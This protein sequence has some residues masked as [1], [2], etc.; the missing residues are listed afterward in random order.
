MLSGA[1]VD[2]YLE[3][4][5]YGGVRVPTFAVLAELH[6]A[7][8]RSV[9]FE[10]LSVRRGEAILLDEQWL[11]EKVV[12]R[13]RGGYCYEL[14]GLLAALLEALGFQ[15]QHLA[16]RVGPTGID[17]DHLA[18]RVELEEP[19]LAD[20]GFGDSFLAPLRLDSRE[21]QDGGEGRSY[22]LEE[23]GDGLVLLRSGPAGWKR[24]FSFGPRGWPLEAFEAGNRYHQSSPD[25]HFTKNTVVSLATPGG[26]V[27][28]SERRLITT[29]H[30]RRTERALDE[31]EVVETL[32]RVFGLST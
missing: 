14:N 9:P 7:H 22:R 26:R 2:R 27:T 29:E 32:R 13:R 4:I 12:G 18:L 1:Q 17:F 10:N 28:L 31:R 6:V 23:G 3:R 30:G 16:G 21:P 25:S 19:W 8:L 20:V 15:V 5:R 11:F 24:Q